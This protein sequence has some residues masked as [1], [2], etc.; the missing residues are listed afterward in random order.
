MGWPHVSPISC[1]I[2]IRPS[3]CRPDSQLLNNNQ[4]AHAKDHIEIRT[5]SR[6]LTI[7][8]FAI[9]SIVYLARLNAIASAP[10]CKAR[11]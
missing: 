5:A 7:A 3:G 2:A 11:I 10:F 6:T 9:A 8:G 4:I 1:V